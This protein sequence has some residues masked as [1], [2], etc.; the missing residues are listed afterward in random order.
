MRLGQL[1][2]N[3]SNNTF[4]ISM[5]EDSTTKEYIGVRVAFEFNYNNYAFKFQAGKTKNLETEAS[6]SPRLLI[7]KWKEMKPPV[8]L[9]AVPPQVLT[10][11][12]KGL[13]SQVNEAAALIRH[14]GSSLNDL[15]DCVQPISDDDSSEDEESFH[16]SPIFFSIADMRR[17]NAKQSTQNR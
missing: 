2:E 11:K 15:R 1:V 13:E 7:A 10:S 5:D 8:K 3:N 14:L 6:L 16:Q 9:A 12:V 17:M 4:T